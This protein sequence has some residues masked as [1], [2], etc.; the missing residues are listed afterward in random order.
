[1]KGSQQTEDPLDNY[2][3]YEA[4]TAESFIRLVRRV[5]GDGEQETEGREAMDGSDLPD[6]PL[7]FEWQATPPTI[8]SFLAAV[9]R[10]AKTLL[11]CL[12]AGIFLALAIIVFSTPMYA[13]RV[14]LYLGSVTGGDLRSELGTAID[15]D[16]NAELIRSDETTAAVIRELD[17]ATLPEFAPQASTLAALV[18]TLRQWAGRASPDEPADPMPMVIGKVR[19]GLSVSRKGNTRLIELRYSSVSSA[20]SADIA[21]A[22]ARA[23][24]A[25]ALARDEEAKMQRIAQLET[26]AAR[27]RQKAAE[28][29]SNVRSLLRG[30]GRVAADPQQIEQQTF[31]LRQQLSMLEA[32]AAAL[33]TKL[34]LIAAYERTGDTSVITL[35]SPASRQLLTELAQ[36][37]DRLAG[38]QQQPGSQPQ[39]VSA[40]TDSIKTLEAS[41]RQE[42]R[43]A[44]S[45]IEVELE[46]TVAEQ[47]SVRDQ[48]SQLNAYVA[49]ETWSALQAARRDKIF[50][51]GAY[52]EYLS[53]L[54]TTRYAP[55]S[56]SDLRIVADA[57]APTLPSSPN[58][59][60]VLAISLTLSIFVGVGLA[61][62]SE[63]KRNERA[64]V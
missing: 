39:S 34:S 47:E 46:T 52:Q 21:N 45:A 22:F 1:M 28:A 54:E 38:I 2:W 27:A 51:D 16:T 58:K 19:K 6:D 40:I 53:Q 43:L 17:L 59:M 62:I 30:T 20:L 61:G 7:E 29:D 49:S 23:H 18:D 37:R 63:W 14:S 15:L 42:V 24:L 26:L 41:L 44:A 55:Q 8:A 32:K 13:A 50:Y 33:K 35:D 12:A 3:L 5:R 11:I 64:R 48:I 36:A 31:A 10:Q 57:V 4:P 60:V 25:G 9:R 56:H